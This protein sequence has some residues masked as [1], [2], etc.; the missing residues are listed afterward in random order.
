M[1]RP[2]VINLNPVE[3]KYYPF[4]ISFDKRNGSC[5]I[6]SPK[7][8]VPKRKTQ[9]LKHLIWQ[10]LKMKLKQW[11]NDRKF[12]KDYSLNPSTCIYEN[13]KY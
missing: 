6:F 3:I 4:M 13:S 5:N 12:K 2:T 11:Q 8:C 7:I 9:T 10:Q 1:V